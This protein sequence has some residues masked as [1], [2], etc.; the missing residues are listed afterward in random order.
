MRRGLVFL[1]MSDGLGLTQPVKTAPV[2]YVV[3][4]SFTTSC[5][6]VDMTPRTDTPNITVASDAIYK[7]R[8]EAEAAM[9]TLTPCNQQNDGRPGS[10]VSGRP[11]I[12]HTKSGHI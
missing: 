3:L 9:T 11:W 6:V 7:T 2:F 12:G 5:S 8:A 4:N 10:I 1:P